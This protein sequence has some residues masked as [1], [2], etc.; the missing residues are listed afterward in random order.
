MGGE[1]KTYSAHMRV[2]KRLVKNSRFSP[3]DL[4]RMKKKKNKEIIVKD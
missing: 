3:I 2:V 1:V 4:A